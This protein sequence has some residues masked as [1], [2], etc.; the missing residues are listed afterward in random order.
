MASRDELRAALRRALKARS[1]DRKTCLDL[2]KALRMTGLD[3]IADLD[4][5]RWI[6]QLRTLD[7]SATAARR[8]RLA[9]ALD[10]IEEIDPRVNAF[11]ALN[12]GM[13]LSVTFT[14]IVCVRPACAW[15]GVQVTTPLLLMLAPAGGQSSA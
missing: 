7:S 11:V 13:P 6:Q 12:G 15:L 4:L 10:R 8:A 2:A 1:F 14:V 5:G 3:P 9:A